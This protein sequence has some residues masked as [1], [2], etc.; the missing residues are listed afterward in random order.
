MNHMVDSSKI[1]KV[2]KWNDPL[3]SYKM[4]AIFIDWLMELCDYFDFRCISFEIALRL[5][6]KFML[7]DTGKNMNI[8]ECDLELAIVA[9]L[10][11]AIKSNSEERYLPTARDLAEMIGNDNRFPQ[12]IIEIEYQILQSVN[13]NVYYKTIY[14][15][16]EKLALKLGIDDLLN[17]SIQA[18]DKIYKLIDMIYLDENFVK[19]SPKIIAL[20]VINLYKST[21]QLDNQCNEYSISN[22]DS[23]DSNIYPFDNDEFVECVG[24]IKIFCSRCVDVNCLNQSKKKRKYYH[25]RSYNCKSVID[26]QQNI[27]ENILREDIKENTA[28]IIQKP[29]VE[30]QYLEKCG[31]GTYSVVYKAVIKNTTK[32]V[33]IK[34]YLDDNKNY[35]GIEPTTI[36]EIFFLKKCNHENIISLNEVI[37]IN[38]QISI[39]YDYCECT[40]LEILKIKLSPRQIKTYIYNILL[41]LEYCH[42][43]N[44]IHADIKPENILLK[45]N[46]VKICDFNCSI[47]SYWHHKPAQMVTL[48]YRPPEILLG[49]VN[50]GTEIDIWS[51]GCILGEMCKSRVLFPG[52]NEIDQIQKIFQL[53][54][55]PLYDSELGKL[56]GYKES[57]TP[58]WKKQTMTPY[59]ECDKLLFNM[60]EMQPSKRISAK[61]ALNSDYFNGGNK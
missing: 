41:G 11:I 28:Y 31:Q 10:W 53:L 4:R 46:Q 49:S 56:S 51:T 2:N 58:K 34:R 18:Y 57:N 24:K 44:I 47:L 38:K 25:Q 54:G 29:A 52:N 20:S 5:I 30:Y 36:S 13:W 50:Y 1:S 15:Y 3:I 59:S 55:T 48:W 7:T 61:E 60:L 35:S 9:C 14:Y 39:I 19:F 33:T 32:T 42:L 40:L 43:N 21:Y 16:V 22:V 6:D 8:S 27:Q 26:Y 37:Y 12:K 17:E 45:N 23:S